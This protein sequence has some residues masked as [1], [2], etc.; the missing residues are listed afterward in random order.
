MP[1]SL[2]TQGLQTNE[3]NLNTRLKKSLLWKKASKNK[4]LGKLIHLGKLTEK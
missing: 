2:A 1:Q 3:Q 4:S